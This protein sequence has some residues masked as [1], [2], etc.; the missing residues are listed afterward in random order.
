MHIFWLAPLLITLVFAASDVEFIPANTT[1]LP[2]TPADNTTIVPAGGGRSPAFSRPY[3]TL[4][5]D[6]T[7]SN[8]FEHFKFFSVGIPL[9]IFYASPLSRPGF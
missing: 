6:A 1:V 7:P 2:G 4:V 8:F 5:T 3:R 9:S